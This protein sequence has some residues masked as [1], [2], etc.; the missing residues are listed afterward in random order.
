V[1][2]LVLTRS[3]Y[4]PGWSLEANYRRLAITEGVT[5][6]LMARQTNRDWTWVVLVNSRDPFLAKRLDVFRR[7][8]P[9]LTPIY[10]EPGELA[11][12]PWD[13]N[14]E[15][16]TLVQKVAATA[17]RAP[18]AEALGD[19]GELIL[20]TRLDDDDGLA[21]DALERTR[22]AA[23]RRRDRTVLMQPVGYRVWRGRCSKVRHD[24]NAMHSLLTP[25]GDELGI[26]DY[27]H[28]RVAA[29]AP[30]VTVD[31][32][33]AWLWARHQDTISGWR[34]ADRPITPAL[35]RLYPIDWTLL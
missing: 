16:T 33:P 12:A 32:E 28:R 22:A 11:G 20:Q 15:R 2:H 31:E 3:A 26:Y 13:P 18:W 29:V 9:A 17:Y 6:R 10:W 27:G 8:A 25:A 19:R 21:L 5:A 34:L 35:R 1:R 23:R 24:T 7:A 30:V 14:A 4:G